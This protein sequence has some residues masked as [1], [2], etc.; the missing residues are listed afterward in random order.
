VLYVLGYEM[1]Y[2]RRIDIDEDDIFWLGLYIRI[3]V[4][5]FIEL[6]NRINY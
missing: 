1:K 6:V 2:S 5:G 4:K 3:W